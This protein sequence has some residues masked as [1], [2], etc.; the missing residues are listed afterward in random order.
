M[1]KDV[2]E[3]H[4]AGVD[5]DVTETRKLAW[6]GSSQNKLSLEMVIGKM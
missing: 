5:D 4:Y 2:E 1:E 3:G 6:R